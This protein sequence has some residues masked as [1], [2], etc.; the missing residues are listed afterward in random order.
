MKQRKF[1]ASWIGI[2]DETRLRLG[3]S[4]SAP[5]SPGRLKPCVNCGK[6][7][8]C[9]PSKEAG[10]PHYEKKCCSTACNSVH[11]RTKQPALFWAK[12]DKGPH[13]KGCWFYTGFIKWDGYGWLARF[14]NGRI[15]HMTAHRY[16][17]I[18]THGDPP[19]GMHVLHHCD[20][21]AC[22]NPDHLWL[23]THQDNMVDKTNKGRSLGNKVVLYPD[24]VRPRRQAC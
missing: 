10:S 22:C 15:R 13:P 21:P 8:W 19:K 23:G 3:E 6:E 4:M 2:R 5:R 24:R 14:H 17:W 16:A 12:V 18:L 9:V 7:F 1:C 20:V 11:R